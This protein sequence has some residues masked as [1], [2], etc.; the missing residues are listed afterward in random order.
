M[1][2]NLS[3]ENCDASESTT[4]SRSSG[5]FEVGAGIALTYFNGILERSFIRVIEFDIFSPYSMLGRIFLG[6]RSLHVIFPEFW[7]ARPA[8][9]RF[10][11]LDDSSRWTLPF[12]IFSLMPGAFGE[13][14]GVFR[15]QFA[16]FTWSRLLG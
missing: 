4:S 5:L 9:M 13:F 16:W 11:L 10:T 3:R 14:D 2:P 7:R 6:A 15:S 1:F 8:L 12:P